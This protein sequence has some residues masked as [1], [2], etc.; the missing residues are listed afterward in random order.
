MLG[1]GTKQ[2]IIK[3]IKWNKTAERVVKPI[4]SSVSFRCECEQM[5]NETRGLEDFRAEGRG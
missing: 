5:V 2:I 3:V 1:T 4:V